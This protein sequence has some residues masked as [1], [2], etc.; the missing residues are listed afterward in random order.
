M[1]FDTHCHLGYD[2]DRDPDQLWQRAEAAG[3]TTLLDVGCDLES[4][5]SAMS[6]AARLLGVHFTAG[7]H[8]NH[9]AQFEAEWEE[10]AQLCRRPDCLAVGETGLDFYRKRTTPEQQLSSLETHIRLALELDKPVVIHCREAFPNT[11][12]VLQ[13]H[14][15]LRGVMHCFSG[16]IP[17]ARQALDLGFYLSFAGPLTYPK[18]EAL[19]QAAAFAPAERVVVE[20]DAPYLPPQQYR[21]KRNEPAHIV[22]TLRKL[23]EVR[24]VPFEE[25]A[26]QTADN[27]HRLFRIPAPA[28]S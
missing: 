22:H 27:G 21:G 16:G 3:V 24:R 8:P 15:G 10:I 1:I 25:M 28:S 2:E 5:R 7:L 14:S 23:A 12:E 9:T 6:C 11:Y 18:A 17:E 4:S 13:Q 26:R 20:T 19:R